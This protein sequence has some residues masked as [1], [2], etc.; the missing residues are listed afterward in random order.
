M[1]PELKTEA[2]ILLVTGGR[3]SVALDP[4]VSRSTALRQRRRIENPVGRNQFPTMHLTVDSPLPL[5]TSQKTR[6]SNTPALR[7]HILT[8]QY[9][10]L[11]PN[12]SVPDPNTFKSPEHKTFNPPSKIRDLQ[13]TT[14][15]NNTS[16]LNPSEF[17]RSRSDRE[18][19]RAA[20]RLPGKPSSVL[21]R[22]ATAPELLN[23]SNRSHNYLER[24]RNH[25]P[26]SEKEL[27]HP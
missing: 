20:R 24:G 6:L 17:R 1:S 25:T 14:R 8:K 22:K 21:N 18:D 11:G 4:V 7:R 23:H 10:A 5:Q 19:G 27:A 12:P 13:L 9:V 16:H 26:L 3:E 15:R 2:R